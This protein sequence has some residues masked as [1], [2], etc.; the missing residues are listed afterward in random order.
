MNSFELEASLVS[1]ENKLDSIMKLLTKESNSESR[2]KNHLRSASDPP[3][4]PNRPTKTL[5]N[6]QKIC[7]HATSA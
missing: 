2:K 4:T 7:T 1:I 5:T 3:T 6:E